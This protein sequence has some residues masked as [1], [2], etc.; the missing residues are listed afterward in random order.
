MSSERPEVRVSQPDSTGEQ[1]GPASR[2]A[3]A[4][5]SGTRST[6][7]IETLGGAAD[8]HD[9][10]PFQ[11]SPAFGVRS[12]PTGWFDGILGAGRQSA[13]SG[14]AARRNT[15]RGVGARRTER[16]MGILKRLTQRGVAPAPLSAA[17]IQALVQAQ[18]Q[19]P[20]PSDGVLRRRFQELASIFDAP[21]ADSSADAAKV[22]AAPITPSEFVR[23]AE[24]R[25]HEHLAGQQA[26]EARGERSRLRWY[27]LGLVG[28]AAASFLYFWATAEPA[29]A[30]APPRAPQQAGPL[31]NPPKA[32]PSMAPPPAA[33]ANAGAR[34]PAPSEQ[35]DPQKQ[36]APRVRKASG[37]DPD[38]PF[39]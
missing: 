28:V 8:P 25:A 4:P 37:S 21:P 24:R 36:T 10:P 27:I 38:A 5:A 9:A 23:R 11:S 31:A 29:T 3:A 19:L 2:E 34:T 17:E 13:S 6:Q 18:A 26:E 22:G 7:A 15:V 20:K 12:V 30:P 33:P 1:V 39:F 14:A 32:K 16:G 35:G